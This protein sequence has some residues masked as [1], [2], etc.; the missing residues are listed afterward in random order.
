M[1]TVKKKLT[2]H[3]KL[4]AENKR[5]REELEKLGIDR[6]AEGRR[7]DAS[8]A[9]GEMLLADINEAHKLLDSINGV[10]PLNHSNPTMRV[11]I[12]ARIASLIAVL[13]LGHKKNEVAG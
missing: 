11:S 6:V 3:D 4:V 9:A 8:M 2:A 12:A 13:T 5:M 7:L 1:K 10:M